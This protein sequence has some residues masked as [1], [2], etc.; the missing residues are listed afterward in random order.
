MDIITHGIIATV[1]AKN[2]SSSRYEIPLLF[3]A[4]ILPDL[5]QIPL[6][7]ILGYMNGRAFYL[8]LNL[9]PNT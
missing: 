8:P 9:V 2:D 3:F 5:F 1:F 7:L 4:G 6:Y